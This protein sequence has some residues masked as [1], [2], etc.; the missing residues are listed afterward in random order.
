MN[1]ILAGLSALLY[2]AADFSG[3]F[4]ARKSSLVA[5]LAISQLAGIALAG[6]FVLVAGT[7]FPGSADAL[8]SLGGGLS[9]IFGLSML[10][11]GIARHKVAIVSPIAALAGAVFPVGFDLARG[12]IPSAFGLAG[13]S[14]CLPAI[15]LLSAGPKSETRAD[16]AA[17]SVG[18]GCAAGL[19]FGGFYIALS[20]TSDGSGLWPIFL[21]RVASISIL[22]AAFFLFRKRIR[23]ARESLPLTFFTGIADMSANVLFLLA[24]RSGLLSIAAVVSSLFPAPTVILARVF[25]KERIPPARI[26][27]IVLAIAGIAL[28]SV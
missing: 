18:H 10:Y 26:A 28:M 23:F 11:R 9:G 17:A 22:A 20:F 25:L 14:L 7:P 8:W 12:A 2:G 1:V 27:G 21:A 3:G 16:D 13:A 15:L 4:A 6:C 24:S 19:G 5:V